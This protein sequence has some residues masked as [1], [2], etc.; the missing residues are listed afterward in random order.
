MDEIVQFCVENGLV[1]VA[2]ENINSLDNSNSHFI[3]F[4][5]VITKMDKPYNKLEFFSVN[6]VSS[7]F[8]K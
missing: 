8:N 1:L 5:S 7:T 3:S 2:I 4:A 6:S